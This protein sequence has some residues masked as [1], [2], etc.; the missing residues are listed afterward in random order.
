MIRGY[1]SVLRDRGVDKTSWQAIREADPD[2]P[3]ELKVSILEPFA[4]LWILDYKHYVVEG[5]CP[6][7][8][9]HRRR[10]SI[11]ETDSRSV[12]NAFRAGLDPLVRGSEL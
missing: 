3:D 7:R 5:D 4:G 10:I 9:S 12:G 8:L 1:N 2:A 11:C 6:V